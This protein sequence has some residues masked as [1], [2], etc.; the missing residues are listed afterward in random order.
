MTIQNDLFR[1]CL[2]AIPEEQKAEFEL[3]FGI[4]ERISEV[5]KAKNVFDKPNEQSQVSLSYAMARKHLLKTN[6]TQK[7][8]AQKLHKRESEISKWLTGRHN[9]TMQTIAKIETALGCKLIN[10]AE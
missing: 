10:I 2:A 3:K 7:D 4:A 1:Q 9:F 8:F 6:L 5:L